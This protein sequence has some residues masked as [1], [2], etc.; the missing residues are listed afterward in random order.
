[1][2]LELKNIEMKYPKSSRQVLQNVSMTA[3]ESFFVTVTGASGSGKSTLLAIA[4][5]YLKPQSGSILYQGKDLYS[6]KEKDIANLHAFEISYVPQ[7]NA[8]FKK[9]TIEENIL[10]HSSL[11]DKIDGYEN[12]KRRASEISAGLQIENLLQRYPFELSGGELKRASIARALINEP[13]LIIA[14]E[15]TTGLDKDT[16]KVILDY[17]L[18]FS[19]KGNCVIIATHDENALK[20]S[21]KNV[22]L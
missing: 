17:L 4:G 8:M 7:S 18:E 14:D 3:D 22:S 19:D 15:P 20:Y 21:N 11:T 9:Y 1:M 13:K 5:G 16:G 2:L 12:K 10:M 6:L